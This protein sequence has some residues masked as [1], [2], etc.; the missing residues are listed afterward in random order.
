M[1]TTLWLLYFL[2][3]QP[4]LTQVKT[5]LL[6]AVF[7]WETRPHMNEKNEWMK[8]V[9]SSINTKSQTEGEK[10]HTFISQMNTNTHTSTNIRHQKWL[11]CSQYICWHMFLAKCNQK[12]QVSLDFVICL[13]VFKKC[14][15]YPKK[16]PPPLELISPYMKAEHCWELW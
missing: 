9:C 1:E 2:L 8:A 12:W 6:H 4:Y 11:W 10:I 14:I 16:K 7:F 5:C 13:F 15:L 3:F